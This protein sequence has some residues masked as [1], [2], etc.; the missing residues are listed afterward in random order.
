MTPL[1]AG[2][3]ANQMPLPGWH[4]GGR[5]AHRSAMGGAVSRERIAS[6]PQAR[7]VTRLGL[8]GA[9]G[10]I[11]ER[12]CRARRGRK[13]LWLRGWRRRR[14]RR[15]GWG[16]GRRPGARVPA[17]AGVSELLPALLDSVR[18]FAIPM[19]TRFRGITVREGALIEGRPGGASSPRSPSTGRASRPAGWPAR[20]RR[21]HHRVA[22]P[23][24]GQRAGQRHRACGRAG[25]GPRHCGRVRLPHGQGP[26]RRAGPARRRGPG[27]GRGRAGRAGPGG[28]DP[29]GRQRRLDCGRGGPP[30]ARAGPVRPGVRRAALR[31]P[32]RAGRTAPAHGRAAGRGRVHPAGRGP[33]EGPRRGRG[34]HR[35]AQGRAAGRGSRRAGDRRGLRPAGGGVQR[36]RVLG[37]AGRRGGAGRG[38]ARAALRLR[39]GHDEPAGRRRD[40]RSAGPSGRGAAQ[41][42]AATPDPARLAAFETDPGPWRARI[43]AAA[44]FLG[45]QFPGAQV[46][47]AQFP[48]APFPGAR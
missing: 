46:P 29:G 26:G 12:A 30:A 48:G 43:S 20:S 25:T 9:P 36:G 1:G 44:R 22:R 28:P 18:A 47:E 6:E 17:T 45:A 11:R 3:R 23:G 21:P 31:H 34:G 35:R 7:P 24:P 5:S 10:P 41:V 2:I 42:R 8:P 15:P 13:R 27:A 16:G 37:R 40:R 32:G 39:P 19:P 33:A 4:V 14:R 38:P